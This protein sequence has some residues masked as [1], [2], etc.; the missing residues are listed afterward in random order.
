MYRDDNYQPEPYDTLDLVLRD[1]LRWQAPP[2]LTM[3]LMR[4]AQ[5]PSLRTRPSQDPYAISS[6]SPSFGYSQPKRW[7]TTLVMLL[8]CV[9]VGLSSAVAW[10][11]YGVVGAEL[12]ASEMWQHAHSAYI[13]GIHQVYAEM[14][15][16]RSLVSSLGTLHEQALLLLNW[17]LVAFVLWLSLDLPDTA[18]QQQQV[19]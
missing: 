14:P 18:R 15:V 17:L 2:D 3:Q 19:S 13:G 6:F 1:E 4:L 7:Y 11:V 5:D 16:T 8:T 9:A 10:Q 12:G